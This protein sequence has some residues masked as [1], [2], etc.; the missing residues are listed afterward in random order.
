MSTDQPIVLVTGLGG[1]IGAALGRALGRDY[2]VVGMGSSELED[3]LK[4]VAD[5]QGRVLHEEAHPEA[6][7]Y[8]RSDHFNFAKAGVPALYV[9]GGEDL[10]EGGKAAGDAAS[11]AYNEARY[12]SPADQYDAKTWK[13]DGAMEDLVSLYTIGGELADSDRW[14]NWYEG[15]PFKAARDA[16]LAREGATQ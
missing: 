1:R 9:D 5:T 14:P 13:L 12:H 8:F 11:R 4:K 6:G 7:G 10:L 16:A 2:T 15:N 3:M